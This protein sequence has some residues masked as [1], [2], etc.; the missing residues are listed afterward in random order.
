MKKQ[1][2]R[3]FIPALLGL[4]LFMLV[5]CN[6][7]TVKK[8]EDENVQTIEAVLKNTFTGPS[9]EWIQALDATEEEG[10]FESFN[11]YLEDLYKDYFADDASY[12][13]FVNSFGATI[14]NGPIRNDYRLK[15]ENI[16]YEQTA[17]KEIIYN[18]SLKLQYQK[19]DSDSAEVGTVNGQA[20]VNA[21]HKIEKMV[22]RLGDF[23]NKIEE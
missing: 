19:E 18:F 13:E 12:L 2:Y 16:E 1:T 22:I 23:W 10:S 7:E 6:N 14:M 3:Y 11:Q 20:N 4:I 9:D 15:V 17:S 5:G 21:D 8:T